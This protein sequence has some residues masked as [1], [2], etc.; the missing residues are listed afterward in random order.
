MVLDIGYC[1]DMGCGYEAHTGHG[2][3]RCGTVQK[4]A[5]IIDQA[6]TVQVCTVWTWGEEMG[7]TLDMGYKYGVLI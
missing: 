1:L 2:Q 7:Y 6:W 5:D 4:L 3:D